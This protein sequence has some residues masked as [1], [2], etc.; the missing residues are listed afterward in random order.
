MQYIINLDRPLK[1]MA[2]NRNFL[3]LLLAL[4]AIA[5]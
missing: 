4:L 2:D 5:P 3:L 1:D